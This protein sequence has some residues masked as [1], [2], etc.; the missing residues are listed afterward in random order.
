MRLSDFIIQWLT[1]K[2]IYDIFT[3]SGGGSI[4]LCDSVAKSDLV[5]YFCCHHEQ[6][7]A[8]SAEGYARASNQIGAALVTTGPGGTNAITGVSSCWIDSIPMLFISGQVYSTQTIKDTKLRQLGVQETNIIDLVRP[9]TKY[10]VSVSDAA[11]I[12]YELE[13]AYHLAVSGRPG[14]VWIDVPADIQLAEIDPEA[15]KVFN[16][17]LPEQKQFEEDLDVIINK[18]NLA[19]RPIIL[20][21]HGVKLARCEEQLIELAEKLNIPILTTWNATDI[22]DSDHP[23][24]IGRP[25]AFAERGAN[26]AIQ[27]A[28]VIITVGTRLPFM[29]T[30]YNVSDFG[31]N[32]Y[33]IMVDIDKA[34]LEKLENVVDKTI[35][36]DARVFID[37]LNSSLT[38]QSTV[39]KNWVLKCQGIRKKYPILEQN[40]KKS[41]TFVNSYFFIKELSLLLKKDAV[42][43]TDMGLSFVGTHQAFKIKKGQKLFTNSG[44]APM[45]WGLPAAFGATRVN[46]EKPVICLTGDGGFMM[47]IQE[48]AT[49]MC[50]RPNLKIF[51]YNNKGY[52]TIKQTQQRGFEN[53]LMGCSDE[54]DM[55]FPDFEQIAG[56]HSI[57]F[58]KIKSD[59]EISALEEFLKLSG[60]GICELIMDPN[61]LQIPIAIN[62]KD[63]QGMTIPS[64][65]E[66]L[67]P[68]LSEEE[69]NE[70]LFVK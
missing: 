21:G 43:V 54:S 12:R 5:N 53:R 3:V 24:F 4:V 40:Y 51:V 25:G 58:I 60:P 44:H 27:N 22:I 7:V 20:A 45:G 66:D 34:E 63:K 32:A 2:G 26:F 19:V 15:L 55:K 61:Q 64:R 48:L 46:H 47:N 14:P 62:K 41:G 33:K 52:L 29:V 28:D 18:I 49:V 31:R 13:K 39:E 37:M 65:Y 70:S 36:M 69:L 67:F 10:A 23:L 59:L 17:L 57:P 42:I 11:D 50:H 6:A 16:P 8:F 35:N 68:F 1:S 9:N 38:G 30:G 56:A